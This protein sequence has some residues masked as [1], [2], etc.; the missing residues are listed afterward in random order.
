MAV[1]VY[2]GLNSAGAAING[3]VDADNAKSARS[4]LRKDGVFP[5]EVKEQ[6]AGSTRGTGLNVEVDFKAMFERVTEKD[7]A[8]MTGQMSTL[9]G[10]GIPIVEALTALIDQVEKPKLEKMLRDIREKVNQGATLADAMRDHP[11]AFPPL[12]VNMVGAG[13]QS[14]SLETVLRRLTVYTEKQVALRGQIVTA[15]TYPALMGAVSGL[16]IIGL[17]VGIIPKIRRVFDSMD[18]ALPAITLAVMW[19][20]DFFLYRWYILLFLIVAAVFGFR[21][22]VRTEAGRH[23]WHRILLTFPIIGNVNRK[24]AVSRFCRTMSTLLDSGVPI[25]TAVSIVKTI[26]GNDIIAEAIGEA[27]RNISE[28]QSIAAPLKASGQFPPLVTH[29]INIGEKTGEIE[30]MLAKVAD[31]YDQE[32]ERTLTGLTSIIEPILI[33]VM[34]GI[35]AIVALAIL[36][37][38]LGMSSMGK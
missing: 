16:I 35:V 14:G 32:V 17:F 19:I 24:V 5:T 1:Y 33:V 22:W 4:K 3:I 21:K 9:V 28:G 2:K 7:V 37:P 11:S 30:P 20:S 6:K 25:L 27:G 12:Y 15:L 36:L 13:E 26:V 38:M 34:G 18:A 31:S 8:A 10:A 29:M 23:R